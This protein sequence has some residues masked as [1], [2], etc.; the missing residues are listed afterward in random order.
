MKLARFTVRYR[1]VLI[2][3][4][5]LA[6]GWAFMHL[7]ATPINYDLTSYLSEDTDTSIGLQRMQAAFEETA[8]FRVALKV[9]DDEAT[10]LAQKIGA[11]PGTMSAAFDPAKNAVEEGTTWRLIE[12]ITSKQ[13][14]E[15]VYDAAEALLNDVP[16][17]SAGSVKDGRTLQNSIRSEMPGV[18]IVSCLIVLV[19][20]LLM[21]H[22][23][24]QPFL[25]FL[26]IAVS[27]VLNMGTNMVFSSISFITFAVT[28]IL[29]LALA[30]DYSIMLLNAYDRE[31][32]VESDAAQAMAR[33]LAATYMPVLSSSL[34]TVAGMLSL[35]TMS[36]TIG[37]D[38]GMV[39]AKGILISML[40][41]FFLMPGLLVILTPVIRK[42]THRFHLRLRGN[43][44]AGLLRRSRGGIAVLLVLLIVA[45]AVIQFGNVYTYTV[46]DFD[47]ESAHL[48]RIFGNA[49]QV[50]LIYPGDGSDEDYARERELL[51][52]L[53]KIEA[54]GKPVLQD[55]FA[56]TTTGAMA[57]QQY[58]AADVAKLLGMDTLRVSMASTLAGIRYPIRGDKLIEKV[59][60]MRGALSAFANEEQLAMLDQVAGLLDTAKAA[61]R[62]NGQGRAVITLNLNSTDPARGRVISEIKDALSAVYGGDAALTGMMVATNDI[63]NSFEGDVRRVSLLTIGAIFLIILFSFR[64]FLIPAILVL[65]IQ[66]AVWINMA[67]SGLLDGS[68]FFMCYLIC[69]ALQ[70]GATIDYG[71]LLTTHYRE[72]RAKLQPWDAVG[73]AL[74]LSLPTLLTSGLALVIAGYAVGFI[75]SVFYISSIGIMLGRGAIASLILVLLLLPCL[76]VWTDRFIIRKKD[77]R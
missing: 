53:G 52:R 14:A 22:S 12:V 51:D 9:E 19:I 56:M 31:L 49:N 4:F 6:T 73:E 17:L 33:A 30:M 41:V 66:G 58:S 15:A 63:A 16:H 77:D 61:F 40:T 21:T 69:M 18:M 26:I 45:G 72:Q 28:A 27:I 13:D 10:A 25:F 2:V 8:S 57:V 71:I 50:A 37:Y 11:L 23:W 74:T 39:L 70:M 46:H 34:T 7:D 68:I 35:V 43:G 59:L 67:I 44:I 1:A 3:L 65:V 38:I 47:D 48:S 55:V 64:S 54:N 5:I 76:L 75:S 60:E 32:A 20:L 24:V 36:F 42:T 62:Q 29:Q